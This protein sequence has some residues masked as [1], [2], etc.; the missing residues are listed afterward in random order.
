[1]TDERPVSGNKYDQLGDLLEETGRAHH[2]ATS[3]GPEHDWAEWYA[4]Y[5]VGKIDPLVGSTPDEPTI[6]RWLRNADERYRSKKER[7]DE[8][9][10]AYARFILDD[11]ATDHG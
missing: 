4:G 11:Y 9:P 6:R 7:E 8:W 2:A 3:G 5:L 1:V 10:R